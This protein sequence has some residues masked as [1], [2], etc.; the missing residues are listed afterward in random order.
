MLA[1]VALIGVI[2][3]GGLKRDDW[4][5]TVAVAL[6]GA[7]GAVFTTLYFRRIKRFE[8]RADEY[9]LAL[10]VLVFD[11]T[12]EGKKLERRHLQAI[13][14]EADLPDKDKTYANG[15]RTRRRRERM[16]FFRMFWPLAIT[17]FALYFTRVAL[18]RSN[19]A[20]IDYKIKTDSAGCVV[21]IAK[22]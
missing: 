4:P 10:D 15:Y 5:L 8:K 12:P 19:S 14:N 18:H 17:L 11:W 9:L 6:V 16:A 21:K 20:E 13:L 7:F 2:A 3:Q 1:T 22:D